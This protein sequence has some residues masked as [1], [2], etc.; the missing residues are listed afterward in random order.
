MAF[1]AIDPGSGTTVMMQVA[2]GYAKLAQRG[3]RPSRS[4]E[5]ASWDGHELGLYGSAAL[6]YETGP[7]LRKNVFQYINTDQLTTGDPFVVSASPG[8]FA[9]MKQIVDIVPTANGK[10]T[11]GTRDQR[12][13]PLLNAMTGGSDHQNF[14]YMLGTPSTREI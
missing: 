3:W 11:L 12:V 4:I 13:D 6:I 14:A 9:F 8:L 2:D 1:G 10:G 7:D 5:I